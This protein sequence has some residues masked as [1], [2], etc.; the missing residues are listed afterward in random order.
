[1]REIPIGD[2]V[3]I[4]DADLAQL[5]GVSRRTLKRYEAQ[6]NGLPVLR[7]GGRKLRPRKACEAWLSAKVRHPNPTRH[8]RRR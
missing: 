1:M 3:A 4:D 7:L 2:D 8:G 6:A 5:W